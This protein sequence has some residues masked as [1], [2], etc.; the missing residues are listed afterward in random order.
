MYLEHE[1]TAHLDCLT[2]DALLAMRLIAMDIGFTFFSDPL[3]LIQE[4]EARMIAMSEQH[5]D[6]QCAHTEESRRTDYTFRELREHASALKQLQQSVASQLGRTNTDAA[7]IA[8]LEA[9]KQQSL[10]ESAELT[11][12]QDLHHTTISALATQRAFQAMRSVV[13]RIEINLKRGPRSRSLSP[14]RAAPPSRHAHA[15]HEPPQHPATQGTTLAH[16]ALARPVEAQQ[17]LRAASPLPRSP[18][19][20]RARS[21][22]AF[23]NTYGD[24]E[25]L[26]LAEQ[27]RKPRVPDLPKPPVY[28]GAETDIV[29]DRLFV[30]ENYLR[31]SNIPEASWPNYIMSL[32]Q[33]KA[34]TAWT[35]VAVP[36]STAGIPVTWEMFK[37]TMLTNFAH[38]DR[39]HQAQEQLHKIRQRTSQSATD[40]VRTFNSLVNE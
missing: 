36:A 31:G 28:K 16:A 29:E 3:H 35:S 17:R 34:L 38:P 33:D 26:Q 37:Q 15:Q 21:P 27:V 14:V 11:R 30:F 5:D 2:P 24:H 40:Y 8:E 7:R 25:M 10:R 23:A 20:R 18:S 6:L 19:P 39:Q 22:N 13:Q 32:L 9:Y 4:I 12:A 1:G